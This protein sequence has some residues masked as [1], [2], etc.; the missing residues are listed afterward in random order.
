MSAWT[1]VMKAVV[2]GVAAT[3]ML[4]PMGSA[5]AAPSASGSDANVAATTSTGASDVTSSAAP[6]TTSTVTGTS[7]D[8]PTKVEKTHT[9]K[10]AEESFMSASDVSTYGLDAQ[11]DDGESGSDGLTD[12]T[13][14]DTLVAAADL[15]GLAT[16][17]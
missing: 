2:G 11:N 14:S 5:V 12:D 7:A 9:P 4:M 1:R 15:D 3:A 16:V 6:V 8:G 10:T 13:G 17:A